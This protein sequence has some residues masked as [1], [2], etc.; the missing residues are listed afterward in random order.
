MMMMARYG[1]SDRYRHTVAADTHR[2]HRPT[3]DEL[4]SREGSRGDAAKPRVG[5]GE[6]GTRWLIVTDDDR[7]HITD[8]WCQT[9]T[10][11]W[12]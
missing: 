2:P 9:L 3:M 6:D 5:D 4:Q 1:C 8:R 11:Q 10:Q 12:N 7:L